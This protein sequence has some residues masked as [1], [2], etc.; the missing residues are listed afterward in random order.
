MTVRLVDPETAPAIA[1]IVV[2]PTCA[3][4]ASPAALIDA[5]DV[6]E[7]DHNTALLMSSVLPFVYVPVATNCWEVPSAMDDDAG[8]TAIAVKAGAVTVRLVDPLTV[9]DVAVIV[10]V[11]PL[12]WSRDRWG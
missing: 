5:M 11:P 10:V 2:E 4:M 12:H 1:E 6:E 3:L 7:D 9:P 8:V